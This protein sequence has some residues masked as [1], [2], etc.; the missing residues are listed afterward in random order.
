MLNVFIF[1]RPF[2]NGSG[3]VGS[4]FSGLGAKPNAEN[5]NKNVFGSGFG[6]AQNQPQ[7]QG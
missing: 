6:N 3:G 5:A 2:G 1:S 4:L 7:T